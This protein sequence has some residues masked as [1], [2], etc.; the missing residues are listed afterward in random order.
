MCLK[1]LG[2]YIYSFHLFLNNKEMIQFKKY[3]ASAYYVPWTLLDL[4]S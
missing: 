2:F 1:E 4:V 3:L